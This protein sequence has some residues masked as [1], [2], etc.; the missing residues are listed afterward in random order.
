[1][2]FPR[3]SCDGMDIAL[4]RRLHAQATPVDP[5]GELHVEPLLDRLEEI[6]HEVMRDV[7]TAQSEHVLVVRPFA[8]HQFDLEPFLLEEAVLDRGENRR[9]ASQADVADPDFVGVSGG[10]VFFAP[11]KKQ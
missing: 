11:S 5:A 1:M 3:R 7:V 6:H 4:R 8:F 9:F 10:G 2:R